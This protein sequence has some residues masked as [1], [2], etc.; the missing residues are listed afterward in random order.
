L[1]R[2]YVLDALATLELVVVVALHDEQGVIVGEGAVGYVGGL[3]TRTHAQCIGL[4]IAQPQLLTSILK[5]ALFT[6][7]P[8]ASLLHGI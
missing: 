4:A 1:V 2:I 8:V 3:I 6:A 5:G 7:Q